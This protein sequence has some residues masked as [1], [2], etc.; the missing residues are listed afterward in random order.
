M[1]RTRVVTYMY[2]TLTRNPVRQV[3]CRGR[4]LIV[5]SSDEIDE[6]GAQLFPEGSLSRPRAP[7][8]DEKSDLSLA[9]GLLLPPS[10]DFD[11]QGPRLRRTESPSASEEVRSSSPPNE[12]DCEEGELVLTLS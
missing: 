4:L 3:E 8:N 12:S 1:V 5:L 2:S 9:S 6:Q 11:K 7:T 10:L